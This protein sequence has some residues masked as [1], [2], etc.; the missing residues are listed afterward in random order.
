MPLY[1][2]AVRLRNQVEFSLLGFSPNPV[3][4]VT[5]GGTLIE[6][7]Y[8]EDY[9]SR[10]TSPVGG[11]AHWSGLAGSGRCRMRRSAGARHFSTY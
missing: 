5:A 6:R 11:L 9:C 2:A 10:D 4:L 8:A 3:I 7:A 1:P